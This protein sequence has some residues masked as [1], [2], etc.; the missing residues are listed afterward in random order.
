MR[1]RGRTAVPHPLDVDTDESVEFVLLDLLHRRWPVAHA[2][3]VQDDIE[4]VVLDGRVDRVAERLGVPD[5]ELVGDRFPLAV[6]ALDGLH[7]SLVVHVGGHDRRALRDEPFRGGPTE[8]R[9]AAGDERRLAIESHTPGC[10]GW[11]IKAR[12]TRSPFGARAT[13]VRV[14]YSPFRVRPGFV[15]APLAADPN[16]AP[17]FASTPF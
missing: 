13:G 8:S 15:T 14:G 3:V 12:G 4:P 2:R 9:S 1:E 6:G 11:Y 7:G 10:A 16:V 5:V 17:Y